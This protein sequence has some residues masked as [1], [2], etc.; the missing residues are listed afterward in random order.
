[1]KASNLT[2]GILKSQFPNA[3]LGVLVDGWATTMDRE[4]AEQLMDSFRE[5]GCRLARMLSTEPEYDPE[6]YFDTCRQLMLCQA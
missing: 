3:V 6:L 1:M 2:L 4:R 5:V